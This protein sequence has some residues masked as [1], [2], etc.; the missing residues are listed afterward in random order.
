MT[1]QEFRFTYAG[2]EHLLLYEPSRPTNFALREIFEKQVYPYLSFLSPGKAIVDVGANVGFSTVLF[3]ALYPS[4]NIYAFEPG[5]DAWEL[6]LRNTTKLPQVQIFDYGLLDV[7]DTCPLFH[8]RESSVTN[9]LGASSHNDNSSEPARLRNA[10][11]VFGELN[12]SEV[13]LLKIDTEGAEVPILRS[14]G[15]RL[16]GIESIMLEY[17]SEADRRE[18]EGLLA[19][20]HMLFASRATQPHRGTVVYVS[21]KLIAARTDLNRLAIKFT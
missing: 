15:T 7:D 2:R 16:D 17:H 9:S 13:A 18:I 3:A 6:L 1:L 12:L 5:R 4:A 11:T 19:R 10:S 21:A 20:T 14:L 8:G